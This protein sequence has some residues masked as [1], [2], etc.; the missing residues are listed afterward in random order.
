MKSFAVRAASALVGVYIIYASYRY[1]GKD[2]LALLNGVMTFIFASE[3][4]NMLPGRRSLKWMFVGMT[5]TMIYVGTTAEQFFLVEL[6]LSFVLLTLLVLSKVGKK[7]EIREAFQQMCFLGFG[8]L[9][10]GVLPIFAFRV[11]Y[12]GD[13][14]RWFTLF[15]CIVFLGDTGAYLVGIMFGK[16]KLFEAVSPK[17]TVEGAIGGVLFSVAT[18]AI[19]LT[20]TESGDQHLFTISSWQLLLCALSVSFVAQAGDLVE[21]LIKR[22]AHVK[23]SGTLIPGHGG[24]MDR[25]DSVYLAAPVYYW[26]IKLWTSS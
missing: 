6:A 21:S 13:D 2:V 7:L 3:F 16:T 11:L 22:A 14:I 19:A 25:L 4:S 24:M 12:T 5:T 15:L 23:D 20:L 8:L 18:A 9:Y 10:C 17:K 26:F 1:G